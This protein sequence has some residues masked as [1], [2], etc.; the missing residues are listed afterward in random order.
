MKKIIVPILIITTILS[1]KSAPVTKDSEPYKDFGIPIAGHYRN[2]E[3][4]K[5]SIYTAASILTLLSAL[6]FAPIGENG[7]SV[8]QL[9]QTYGTPIS[10]GLLG[11]TASIALIASPID[12]AVSYHKRNQ[13]IIELNNIEWS[14]KSNVTKYQAIINHRKQIKLDQIENYRRKFYEGTITRAEVNIVNDD[15]ELK[16]GLAKELEYFSR[17]YIES[18][19][20][21]D[22]TSDITGQNK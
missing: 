11:V 10:L 12:T 7:K 21:I 8:T 9:D 22:T 14:D 16:N 1:C 18:N 19:K 5:A 15:E 20:N 13:K 4:V 17:K 2:G 3:M 6:V